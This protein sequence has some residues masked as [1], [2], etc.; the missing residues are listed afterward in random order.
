[1]TTAESAL[2]AVETVAAGDDG[3]RG[4]TRSA[5]TRA[6]AVS[7][8]EDALG[9][10]AGHVRVDPAA[11]RRGRRAAASELTPI[12]DAA[13]TTSPTSASRSAAATS[14]ELDAVAAPLEQVSAD[15][16]A[17]IDEHVVKRFLG[18]FLGILTAIGGFVDMG[19]LV[20][21]AATGARF[22]MNLAWVVVVGVVGIVVYAEMS[23]RVAA[24]CRRPVFDLVRER[25]GPRFGAGQPG[26]PRS[27]STS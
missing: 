23:G 27:S 17:F 7:E 1:M 2:S 8:Q 21:N 24:I 18:V 12:L 14:S 15:L 20:A 6:V 19:D 16:Q 9:G 11:R 4:A 25:L 13:S 3:E 22:G 10:V 26:R 5:A